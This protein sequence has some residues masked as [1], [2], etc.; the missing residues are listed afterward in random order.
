MAGGIQ[1]RHRPPR[2]RELCLLGKDRDTPLPLHVIGIQK[3]VLVVHPAQTA[4]SAALVQHS[5]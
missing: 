2:Q 3:G 5:L 4:Q 1:Q